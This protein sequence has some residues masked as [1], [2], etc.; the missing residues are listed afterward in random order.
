MTTTMD[1]RPEFDDD[2]NGGG[3]A[4]FQPHEDMVGEEE[5]DGPSLLDILQELRGFR[6]DNKA[7][8]AEIKQELNKTNKRMDEAES[9][10][11]EVETVL[12]STTVLVNRLLQRQAEMEAKMVDAE[13]RARRGNIRLYCVSEQATTGLQGNEMGAFVETML[14]L[15]LDF[16]AETDFPAG[17]ALNWC[18]Y[19]SCAC[20]HDECV[21]TNSY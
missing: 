18:T 16:P 4:A 15:A 19:N 6:K 9:R 1:E 8:L 5:E 14:K 11:D 10:I 3:G 2:Q 13:G 17:T 20:L 12:Q 21:D 7:Q